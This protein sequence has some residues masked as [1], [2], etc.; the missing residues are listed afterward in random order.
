[1]NTAISFPLSTFSQ[2]LVRQSAEQSVGCALRTI[3]LF[4]APQTRRSPKFMTSRKRHS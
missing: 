3:L 4:H 1:M 2:S